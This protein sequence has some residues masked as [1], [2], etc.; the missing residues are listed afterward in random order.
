DRPV[1][2]HGVHRADLGA[3]GSFARGNGTSLNEQRFRECSPQG[4]ED[5]RRLSVDQ[6]WW[7]HLVLVRT[8]YAEQVDLLWHLRGILAA[9]YRQT[10]R[11]TGRDRQA[12]ND[13]TD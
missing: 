12:R 8:R 13:R 11:R 10:G 4:H 3:F 1:G 9:R 5:P 6:F 7:L 2:S